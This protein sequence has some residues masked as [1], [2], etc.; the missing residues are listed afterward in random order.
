[1]ENARHCAWSKP[2]TPFTTFLKAFCA[3]DSSTLMDRG[4]L[5]L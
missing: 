5:S 3:G 2:P 4:F 1:L